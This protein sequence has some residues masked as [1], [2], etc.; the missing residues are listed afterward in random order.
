MC[1]PPGT[2]KGGNP[3]LHLAAAMRFLFFLSNLL[4]TR[5]WEE[6]QGL[7]AEA[8]SSQNLLRDLLSITV[9]GMQEAEGVWFLT[10]A[11]SP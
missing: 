5:R 10:W 8:A 3:R 7:Q 11:F 1:C 9:A 4:K 6:D 2:G